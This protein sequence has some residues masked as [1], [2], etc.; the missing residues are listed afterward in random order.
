MDLKLYIRRK[1]EHSRWL[2]LEQLVKLTSTVCARWY[3]DKPDTRG[4]S[5]YL[6]NF[7]VSSIEHRI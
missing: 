5:L 2:Q 7:Q 4:R 6:P 3:K 1:K